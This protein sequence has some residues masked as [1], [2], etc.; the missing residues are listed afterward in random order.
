MK[1]DPRIDVIRGVIPMR[2]YICVL[3][4]FGLTI[5]YI[6]RFA[7]SIA[8]TEMVKPIQVKYDPKGCSPPPSDVKSIKALPENLLEWNEEQQGIILSSFFWGY[9]LTQI[10]GG[11]I[12]DYFGPRR[13]MVLSAVL[14]S[15]LTLLT[16]TAA[17]LDMWALVA[18]RILLGLAQGCFYAS[19]H[20]VVALWVPAQERGLWGT[21]VFSGAHAG[22]F[23]QNLCTGFMLSAFHPN[24]EYVFYIWG[25]IGLLWSII[26]YF[27][28]YDTYKEVPSITEKEV[29]IMEAYY[30]AVSKK[31]RVAFTP[32]KKI[33]KSKPV[34]AILLAMIGH[35]WGLFALVVDIPKFM[36]SYLKFDVKQNGVYVSLGYLALCIFAY[37]SG[38]FVD[39]IDKKHWMNRTW[40]RI[41]FTTIASVG[42]SLGLI[43]V[44]YA[45]CN[46]VMAVVF[47][48]FGMMTM[49]TFYP[50]LKV[51]P[52]D[53]APNH[54]GTIGAMGH[55]VGALSGIIVPY[56][57]GVITPNSTW[58]EWNY[59]WWLTFI[60]MSLTNVIYVFWASGESQPWNTEGLEKPADTQEG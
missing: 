46:R 59:V 14:T 37:A 19:I 5:S 54:S 36:K 48:I 4:F 31:N 51:N 27:T 52:I 42:P 39:I 21:I 18:C 1:F 55:T 43:G 49:G 38:K 33:L 60:V 34:W 16:P 10:P 29:A 9:V 41:L 3:T 2:Y 25:G 47:L 30:E 24:W 58:Q 28:T 32:W 50:S 8:I 23:L 22:N 13:L 12:A 53:L 44:S 17:H 40:N 11:L 35:D 45:A 7:I 57:I 56:V 15:V 20:T 6:M 26:Y